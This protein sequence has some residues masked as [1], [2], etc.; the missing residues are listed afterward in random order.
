M[1]GVGSGDSRGG[2]SGWIALVTST[3]I[4][5][6]VGVVVSALVQGYATNPAALVAI[7]LAAILIGVIIGVIALFYLEYQKR[8]RERDLYLE[9][10]IAAEQITSGA[11]HMARKEGAP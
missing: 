5:M 6:A 9:R 10:W 3:P 1:S 4:S 11:I 8:G 2:K 7:V